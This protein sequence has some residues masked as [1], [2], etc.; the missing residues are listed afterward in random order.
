MSL[1]DALQ[2]PA[3]TLRAEPLRVSSVPVSIRITGENQ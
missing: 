3:L 1:G 2:A